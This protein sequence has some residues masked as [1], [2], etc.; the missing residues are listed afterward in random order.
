[1]PRMIVMRGIPGSGKSTY[2]REHYP[3]ARIVSA[4]DFFV[5]SNGE[6]VFNVSLIQH[7]HD[8]AFTRTKA[9]MTHTHDEIVIDNTNTTIWEMSPYY[10]LARHYRY[11]IEI[12][13]IV[14]DVSI[15]HKRCVHGVPLRAIKR[16]A[17]RMEML[18]PFWP[19]ETVVVL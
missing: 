9:A 1:M 6:Y 13:R 12:V 17:E 18:P 8:Y 5:M 15:A 10:M 3:D 2:A 7:A 16:M 11:D 14:C 4:D 19:N